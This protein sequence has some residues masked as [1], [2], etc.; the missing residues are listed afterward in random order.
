MELKGKTL[1]LKE[2]VV[3]GLHR[4]M[5]GRIDQFVLDNPALAPVG[6]YLKRGVSNLITREDNRI[7][8]GIDGLMLFIADGQGNYDMGMLFDDALS[9]FKAMPETPFDLGL[10]HGTAG[11][12]VIR[13]RLPDNPLVSLFMGNTGAIKLTEEDFRELKA[14]LTEEEDSASLPR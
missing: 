6:K 1:E 5:D 4:W 3:D 14:V 11:G 10:L 8:K 9:M 7:S 2:K 13:V 12:G